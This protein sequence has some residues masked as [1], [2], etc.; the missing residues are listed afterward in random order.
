MVL[1][2]AEKPTDVRIVSHGAS[3]R[4]MNHV[5]RTNGSCFVA[6]FLNFQKNLFLM[7]EGDI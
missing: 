5:R 3:F 7:R 4:K 1:Q 6:Y 2:R